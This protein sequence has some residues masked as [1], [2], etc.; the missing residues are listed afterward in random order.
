MATIILYWM[1]ECR[2]EKEKA[3]ENYI[4]NFADKITHHN[5]IL[6]LLFTNR[7]KQTNKNRICRVDSVLVSCFYFVFGLFLSIGGGS[8]LVWYIV[9]D[10]KPKF[11]KANLYYA[12]D[13]WHNIRFNL[14]KKKSGKMSMWFHSTFSFT[15][16]LLS[17]AI[18]R[19]NRNN[20]S[21]MKFVHIKFRF[22]LLFVGL[23]SSARLNMWY[24]NGREI[25]M[26]QHSH[27]SSFWC[28]I[29]LGAIRKEWTIEI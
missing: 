23:L 21:S 18:Q 28:E 24:G 14:R 22:S 17:Q 27:S 20:R 19:K 5:N 26:V 15:L 4:E 11:F 2:L 3:T 12:R 25:V 1:N 10:I 9:L 29:I 7:T 6:R 16:N 13:M 8:W